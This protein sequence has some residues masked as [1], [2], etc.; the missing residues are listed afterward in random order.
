MTNNKKERQP[1]SHGHIEV[2]LAKISKDLLNTIC[3]Y[4]PQED[5]VDFLHSM[6]A[7]IQRKADESEARGKAQQQQATAA[8]R[9]AHHWICEQKVIDLL[10]IRCESKEIRFRYLIEGGS[11]RGSTTGN[12]KPFCHILCSLGIVQIHANS[13]VSIHHVVNVDWEYVYMD[14]FTRL[15][16]GKEFRKANMEQLEHLRKRGAE[17]K[18]IKHKFQDCDL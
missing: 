5:S 6:S 1:Q 9:L 17:W 11:K 18:A 14:D 7:H 15:K 3:K 16:W 8:T 10:Y 4:I 2:D 12:L 13:A